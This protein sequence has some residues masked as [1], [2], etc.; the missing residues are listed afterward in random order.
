MMDIKVLGPG[1]KNCE[2]LELHAVQA[3][4]QIQ[5]ENPKLEITVKKVTDVDSFL[6]YDILKASGKHMMR[7]NYICRN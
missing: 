1:C 6:D 2:R 7:S 5:A 4:E 3:V